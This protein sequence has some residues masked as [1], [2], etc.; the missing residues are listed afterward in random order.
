MRHDRPARYL[1]IARSL[2]PLAGYRPT[3][4]PGITVEMAAGFAD[5]AEGFREPLLSIAHDQYQL[6]AV[7][8]ADTLELISRTDASTLTHRLERPRGRALQI[9]TSYRP[10]TGKLVTA[11]DGRDVLVH[12]VASLIAAPADVRPGESCADQHSARRFTGSLRVLTNR[13][14]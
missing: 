8:S 14:E 2:S 9:R 6:H 10:E 3:L 1:R 13:F 11:V 4:N 5:R 12:D 7:H